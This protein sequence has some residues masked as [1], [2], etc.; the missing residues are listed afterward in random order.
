[1]RDGEH[2]APN[3][4]GIVAAVREPANH[5][6]EHVAEEVFG[7]GRAGAAQVPEDRGSELPVEVLQAIARSPRLRAV[8]PAHV[9]IVRLFGSRATGNGGLYAV[10]T[11]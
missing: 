10:E 4:G 6:D 7:F 9:A 5:R 1:M 11:G 2:P 3:R 8:P